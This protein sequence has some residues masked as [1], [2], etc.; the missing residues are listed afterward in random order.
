MKIY[1]AVVN[2]EKNKDCK[3]CFDSLDPVKIIQALEVILG[4][5]IE[6]GNTL[7]FLDE[8]QECP[9]AITALR[10]FKE[11]MPQLHVIAAGSLLEFVLNEEEFS[12]PVGRVQFL[13]L[14]P[15]SF[16]EFLNAN[17]LSI[18]ISHLEKMDLDNPPSEQIHKAFMKHIRL[19]LLI[20]G[21]P[22]VVQKYVESSSILMSRQLE[23]SLLQT[24]EKDFGKYA[25]QVQHQYLHR[26]FER[27]PE[28]IGECVKYSKIDPE[29]PNPAR[30]YKQA[31][32]LLAKAGLIYPIHAT[33]ANGLPLRAEINEKK[34]KL[35][36]LDVGLLQS[37]MDMDPKIFMAESAPIIN[38]GP[39]AAGPFHEI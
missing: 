22:A 31:I 30:E 16:L 21:M 11:E 13:Y 27:S 6:S 26:V 34:F 2:F 38:K 12:F 5:P 35:L 33:A 7:L 20:G 28:F 9:Q 19:Y 3:T 10:Y 32:K 4:Q 17:N 1:L 14:R 39:V 8:I 25:P 29:A 36:F 24:F 37:A 15:M 18:L 23:K